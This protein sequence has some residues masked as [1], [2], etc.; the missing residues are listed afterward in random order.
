MDR[1][2]WEK[3]ETGI[4]LSPNKTKARGPYKPIDEFYTV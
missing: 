1:V 4:L 2:R 3:K